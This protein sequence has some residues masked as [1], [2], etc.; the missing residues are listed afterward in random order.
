MNDVI[1]KPEFVSDECSRFP[2]GNW[3]GCCVEH[4]R[5]YWKGGTYEDRLAADRRLRECVEAKGHPVI[6]YL[7]YIGV[8]LFGAPHW[9]TPYRWGYKYKWYPS[10]TYGKQEKLKRTK[11]L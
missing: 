1:N 9:P 2:E 11:N 6:A 10:C 4:D 7:M 8:R 3:G 5:D